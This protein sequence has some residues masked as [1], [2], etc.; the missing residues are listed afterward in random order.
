MPK[1]S[2]TRSGFTLVELLVVIAI[3]GVLVG[4]LLPA[5]QAAREAARRMSCSNNFKQIGLGIHNYHSAYNNLPGH[6]IGTMDSSI[7]AWWHGGNNSN[8]MR[9]SFLVGITPFIEQQAVWEII[10]NPNDWN[11]D[12]VIDFPPMGPIPSNID[13][14]PWATEI[15]TFRCPSDP[16]T[17]LPALGRTNYAACMGDV[18]R[19]IQ[20]GPWDDSKTLPNNDRATQVRACHRGVFRFRSAPTRFRDVLD[21]L[22]NTI[23]AGEI[24]TDLG[25]RDTRTVGVDRASYVNMQSQS[26]NSC[27]TMVDPARPQFW[28]SSLAFDEPINVRGY[29]WADAFTVFSGFITASPPNKPL[30]TSDKGSGEGYYTA[31]SRHQGGCHVL[32]GDGAVKFITDSIE[33]GNQS[34]KPVVEWATSGPRAPGSQSPYGLW[35]ALGTR[36]NKEVID[37]EF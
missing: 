7:T 24:T 27:D 17:G 14:V 21:G 15:G 32:M 37:S 8:A 29:R 6:G 4:L 2:S 11:K 16:G 1:T 36:A 12:N 34:D 10:A 35:G 23:M 25:D 3:I 20:T 19:W 33:S 28:D 5:V 30:C 31:S 9:L 26:P 18:G 13:Y 22:S